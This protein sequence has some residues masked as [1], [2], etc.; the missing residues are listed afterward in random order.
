[1]EN[2]ISE[3]KNKL[4]NEDIEVLESNRK[5]FDYFIPELGDTIP[6]SEEE[7]EYIQG[8]GVHLTAQQLIEFADSI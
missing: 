2:K 3:A 4:L 1:M 7:N 6:I 8:F 5:G